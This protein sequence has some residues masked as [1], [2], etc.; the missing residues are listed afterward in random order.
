M[1]LPEY[2]DDKPLYSSP[3]SGWDDIKFPVM[4]IVWPIL[5][6][7]GAGAVLY[8]LFDIIRSLFHALIY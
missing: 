8:G 2:K 7:L 5:L 6:L 1:K 4:M 3:D